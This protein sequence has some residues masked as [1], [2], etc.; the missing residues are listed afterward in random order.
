[1]KELFELKNN[2]VSFAPQVLL[3][4]EFEALW[5]RDKTKNKEVAVKELGYIYYTSDH[6]SIYSNYFGKE[7]I[8]R[9][10]HDLKFDKTWKEDAP[11]KSAI[12]KYISLNKTQTR[13]LLEDVEASL[14]RLRAYFRSVEFISKDDNGR[15]IHDPTDYMRNVSTLGKLIKG[16]KELKDEV[17]K[18]QQSG[19]TTRGGRDKSAFEDIDII[20][21][22]T[23]E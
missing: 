1:M 17:L 19:N 3:I 13:G 23:G 4:K 11:L 12:D 20:K 21:D 7:K 9:I 14:E 5:K 2:E 10:K 8:D 6:R 16:V 18:E 15:P 22:I